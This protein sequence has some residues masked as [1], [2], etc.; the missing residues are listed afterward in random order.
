LGRAP[1][2]I[3]PA[4]SLGAP[5]GAIAATAALCLDRFV[6]IIG[7]KSAWTIETGQYMQLLVHHNEIHL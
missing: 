3:A 4:G 5:T 6:G 1:A 7:S 2:G